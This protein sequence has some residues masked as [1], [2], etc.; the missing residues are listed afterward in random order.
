[1]SSANPCS[2]QSSSWLCE[3]NQRCGR[4]AY[5]A[6]NRRT[7]AEM[8]RKVIKWGKRNTVFRPFH[9][10]DDK[11]AIAAWGLD[12]IRILHVFNVGSVTFV[13]QSLT[14]HFQT[15][16][17]ITADVVVSDDHRDIA[18]TCAAV[19]EPRHNTTNM[20]TIVSNIHHAA[21]G[22]QEGTDGPNQLVNVACHSFRDRRLLF[23]RLNPG[24]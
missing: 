13:L 6:L 18:S 4:F 12:L 23:P 19:S 3:L 5:K 10:K 8:Q 1:M 2:R 7:V 24:Q 15:E 20:H 17:A 14:V 21:V 11:D 22:S 9:L 16:L